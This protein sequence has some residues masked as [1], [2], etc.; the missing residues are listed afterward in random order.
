MGYFTREMD[1]SLDFIL[2]FGIFLKIF[3]LF[4]FFFKRILE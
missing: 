4:E 2:N 1:K 3:G